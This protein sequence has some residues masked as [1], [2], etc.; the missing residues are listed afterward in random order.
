MTLTSE[1]YYSPEANREYFSVSQYKAFCRC[2]AAALAELRGEWA[3]EQ[4]D[5][6]L[7]GSYV[8]AYFS[9]LGEFR[10]FVTEH[11][12]IQRKDGKLLAKFE[13]ANRMIERVEEDPVLMDYLTGEKQAIVTGELWGTDWKGK[14]DVLAPDRIVDLK[15]IRDFNDVYE[16][17]YG[18]RSWIEYWGYDLQGAIYQELVRQTFGSVL[19]FYI[20]AVTKEK[21]PDIA[22][23]EIPQHIMDT[24][25][26]VAASR[27][28][29]LLLV[30]MGI[31]QPKRCGKCDYC[32][33]TKRIEGPVVYELREA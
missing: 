14:I 1:N 5:A 8:D 13:H 9:G 22:L 2:E 10:R 33:R 29:R 17:G 25:R 18:R 28:D 3:P 6:L 23:I 16:D 32:K 31:E 11:P 19:P 20:A 30:K 15:T 12:E 26:D 7:I 21:E 4:T 24:A 27:I